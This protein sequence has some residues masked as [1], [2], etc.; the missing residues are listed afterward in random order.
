M[1]I[2]LKKK[3]KAEF[4][5]SKNHTI[6]PLNFKAQNNILTLGCHEGLLRDLGSNSEEKPR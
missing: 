3:F 5:R 4:F 6:K 1:G 2:F